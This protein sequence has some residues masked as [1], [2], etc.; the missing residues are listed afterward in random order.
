MKLKLFIKMLIIFGANYLNAD[1][2]STK[3]QCNMSKES[4]YNGSHTFIRHL[5][6]EDKKALKAADVDYEKYMYFKCEAKPQLFL[7]K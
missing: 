3:V 1:W 5:S 4:G 6:E 7:Y 2:V